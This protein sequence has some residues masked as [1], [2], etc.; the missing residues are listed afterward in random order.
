MTAH[1]IGHAK[2]RHLWVRLILMIGMVPV[3]SSI[4][5]LMDA[6]GMS[7]SPFIAPNKS[8]HEE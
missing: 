6:Y 5:H 2:K 3:F 4:G 8:G 1:E 7:L